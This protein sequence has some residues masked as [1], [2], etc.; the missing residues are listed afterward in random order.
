MNDR[1]LFQFPLEK[2]NSKEVMR[3]IKCEKPQSLDGE[4]V[5]LEV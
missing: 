2:E 5:D 4:F 3:G 1:F